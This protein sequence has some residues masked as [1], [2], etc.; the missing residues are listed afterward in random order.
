MCVG[1]FG[2]H[3]LIGCL[4]VEASVF[5]RMTW[6]HV[7]WTET[8]NFSKRVFDFMVH[9]STLCDGGLNL[10]AQRSNWLVVNRLCVLGND[11]SYVV[12]LPE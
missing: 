11:V 9:E 5:V 12:L 1:R 3:G 4:Y 8:E 6:K 7:Q 10:T 2:E